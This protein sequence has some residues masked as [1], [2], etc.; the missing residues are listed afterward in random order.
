MGCARLLEMEVQHV[1]MKLT[2]RLDE[3][4]SPLALFLSQSSSLLPQHVLVFLYWMCVFVTPSPV[5]HLIILIRIVERRKRCSRRPWW[6]H[7]AIMPA[8]CG[9]STISSGLGEKERGKAR[10]WAPAPVVLK[11]WQVKVGMF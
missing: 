1:P 4:P 7:H 9:L 8:R 6:Q 2:R 11:T 5:P 10:F 3:G